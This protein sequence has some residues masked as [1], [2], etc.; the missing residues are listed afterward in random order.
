MGKLLLIF[1]TA[2][3]ALFAI[4]KPWIGVVSYYVL[5]VLAPQSI[6]YWI[7]GSSRIVYIVSVTTLAGF[8]IAFLRKQ[9][10]FSIL[11]NRLNIYLMILWVALVIS[12]YMSPYG[13][14]EASIVDSA[15]MG[16]H[17]S[18][19][20]DTWHIMITFHK[21]LLFYFVSVLLINDLRKLRFLTGVIVCTTVYYTYWAHQQFFSGN[22][23]GMH[24][25]RLAGP[26]AISAEIGG[27]Y[28]D[29]NAFA[30]IFV[31]GIP[32]LFFIGKHFKNKF[33]K[34]LLWLTI[35]F[36]WHAIFLTGSLGGLIGLSA[37]TLFI[38]IRSKKK[39][40]L[41]AI[42]IA[43]LIAFLYQGGDYLKD[44]AM[45]GESG[46][47]TDLTTAQT[48]FQSWEA[49][50]GM[51]KAHPI[52]GVGLGNFLRA[53]SDFSMTKPYVAHNTLIQLSAEAGV[54]AGLMFILI[55]LRIYSSYR[56]HRKRYDQD[57]DT[58]IY[59][60]NEAVAGS[61]MG[62]YVCSVSLNLA[63]YEI[64]YYL[65]I[66]NVALERC[67]ERTCE[68]IEKANSEENQYAYMTGGTLQTHKG[69]NP[70]PFA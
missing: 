38:A 25:L 26:G 7:F 33:L 27:L 64:F 10:D 58:F 18:M 31:V 11:K 15:L 13:H 6:W 68:K 59:A 63:T 9:I 19:Q 42:P 65:I 47:L 46:E 37:V 14:G 66:L 8:V 51:I 49:G 21:T 57:R 5:S 20:T 30:M 70:E 22:L 61:S 55:G 60:L 1:I 69:R 40:F 2:G 48:R 28:T 44:K 4:F 56:N 32:F 50:F 23:M 62:F 24:G 54:L 17:L 34:Y 41:F 29:E 45:G 36:A 67:M 53:Y 35:P 43:L 52:T 12:F 39:S 16:E 3:T